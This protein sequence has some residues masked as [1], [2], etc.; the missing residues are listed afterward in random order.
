MRLQLSAIAGFDPLSG[1]LCRGFSVFD[2]IWLGGTWIVRSHL[3]FTAYHSSRLMRGGFN[4]MVTW[5]VKFFLLTFLLKAMLLSPHQPLIPN[6]I[7]YQIEGS[8]PVTLTQDLLL[9]ARPVRSVLG[10]E[11]FGIRKHL[12][13][14]LETVRKSRPPSYMPASLQ[15]MPVLPRPKDKPDLA[16]LWRELDRRREAQLNTAMFE[17]ASDTNRYQFIPTQ[18]KLAAPT[19]L[20]EDEIEQLDPLG[21]HQKEKILTDSLFSGD[22]FDEKIKRA[23]VLANNMLDELGI[24]G[25]HAHRAQ[26]YLVNDESDLPIV[27]DT[28]AS[29]S[30]T[31]FLSD[32]VG[33]LEE[34][35]VEEMKGLV[36]SVQV[37]GVGIVEWVIRDAN[38]KVG[39][40]RTKAYYIPKA[41]IRLFCPQEYFFEDNQ[42]RAL[43]DH[44][45]VVLR[46]KD[47][48]DLYF[49]WNNGNSLPVML[50]D[51]IKEHPEVDQGCVL[52]LLANVNEVNQLLLDTNMNLT[53]DQ[54]E[55]LLW[56][57]RLGHA[58]FMWTQSLMQTKNKVEVGEKADPPWLRV[59]FK[60]A[61][62]CPH[63]KCA[64][65][66]LGK[67]HRRTPGSVSTHAKP[68]REMAIRRGNLAPG[69]CVSIDQYVCKTPGRLATT[70]GKEKQDLRYTGGTIFVDHATSFV[71]IQ[72]QVSL[73][74]GET[75]HSKWK[76]ET[77]LDTLGYRVKEYRADNQ[78]FGAKEFMDDLELQGQQITFSGVGAHFQN[79]VAERALQ[80]IT[81]WARTMMM[82]QLVHWPDQFDPSLW[83][84]A[85]EHAAHLWN[86]MPKQGQSFSPLEILSRMKQPGVSP[87]QQARVW[88]CPA[89]VLDPQLHDSGKKLPKW[90]PRSHLGMYL[91]VS[92][93]HAPTVGRILNL[94][95]GAIT[96]QYHIM[97]DE[98]FTT[99]LGHGTDLLFN[100]DLWNGMLALDGLQN[101][102]DPTDTEDEN[103]PFQELYDDFVTD[104][105]LDEVPDLA[106]SDTES[107]D[108]DESVTTVK[109]EDDFAS[110]G[111]PAILDDDESSVG[112]LVP[113][114]EES[115]AND[116][117]PQT[118]ASTDTPEPNS[119]FPATKATVG[120]PP[121][122]EEPARLPPRARR[123][124]PRQ[125]R[126]PAG[127]RTRSGNRRTRTGRA[128]KP[129]PRFAGTYMGYEQRKS[130]A[131]PIP[132]NISQAQANLYQAGANPNRKVRSSALSSQYLAT[133]D[134]KPEMANAK[135]QQMKHILLQMLKSYDEDEGTLEEWHPLAFGAKSNDPD[136]MDWFEA[137]N[138]PNRDGFMEAA[139]K[140]I[141]TLEQMDVWEVVDRKDWMN[142]LPSTWAFRIKRYPNGE[143]RKLKARFCV[144]GDRQIAN[145]DYFETFA[146]VVNWNTVRLLL[147]LS[148]ELGLANTQ[149][150]FV[151]A[152]V[153]A[154]IDK[155]PDYDMMTPEEQSRT[156]VFVEM[157][158]GFGQ[159]GRVLKLKKSLYGLR[160]AP[161]NF[162]NH[163]KGILERIGFQQ[164]VDVDPC[165]FISDKVMILSYVDDCLFFA[166][167]Q[168]DVD[169][170]IAQLK[171][172]I[173]LEVEDDVAGFLGVHIDKDQENGKVTLTQKGL[174]QKII[175]ALDIAD[176]PAV[177][178]PATEVLGKDEDGDPADCTF[179]YAS[180]VGALWYLYGHSRPDL[181]F[182]VSQAARF[183]FAPKRSHELALIRIGQY[184][185]GTADKGMIMKPINTD[186]LQMDVYVDS[187]FMGL[188]GKEKRTDPT[189]AKSRSGH[190]ILLNSC[191]IIWSSK[192]QD[193]IA[194]STMMA[195]Y[196]A[197]SSSMREVLPL[198]SLVKVISKGCGI[199]RACE[200]SFRTT[201]WEDN[202][203][204]LTLANL[205]PGQQT[206]RSKH[207]DCRV[208]WF[209]S[210]L[211]SSGPDPIVVEKVE[212]A[213]QL[214]DLF[215]KPLP[216]ETF[217]KL[218]KLLMGW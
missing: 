29:L 102:L 120:T 22:Y 32:F 206:P 38:G 63:P 192:L 74:T 51:W 210:H 197:L 129:N 24:R 217:Q 16:R 65:C 46:T 163:L 216:R 44:K 171:K 194:L 89:Y 21:Y 26:A 208:H 6:D 94:R 190:V 207:Y 7:R 175:D 125:A 18:V 160:Q 167:D 191:P 130:K 66:Q 203:G 174:I 17:I 212:S 99:V 214:A 104:L 81:N 168:S 131:Q 76:M 112:T 146:P 196:Y 14:Q 13:Y 110:D 204:A 91:G 151:A 9:P 202:N 11:Q 1:A 83:P 117:A 82:H 123:R 144:R 73:R 90:K 150:D 186:R 181:G 41:T 71:Y 28:G 201:V 200:T 136:T 218:R 60:G 128:V 80:T 103:L 27:F 20:F 4:A 50:P 165:L 185:K 188:H 31:P 205:D 139:R 170:A 179:N 159:P 108:D 162:F 134:W 177:D 140:E 40:I 176:L 111:P 8:L 115:D 68:E 58:G 88:G 33:E 211:N 30:V 97:F 45:G 35:D 147:T 78:P 113:R 107:N 10:H 84:F 183:S 187:D 199:E 137:M 209:R 121:V 166:R 100:A 93:T 148:A 70:L 48:D 25:A 180:V 213:L 164:A 127:T 34:P 178:T 105:R 157:P 79:G 53:Q 114:G 158:R 143:I 126:I 198:R 59:K 106:P 43:L 23:H 152:F 49:P 172:H 42:T 118:I 124:Q 36:D 52:G 135:T 86:N 101:N 173:V 193:S 2:S 62:R 153:N 215:T 155:P 141:E 75:L 169:D 92:P 138:G 109:E 19:F 161:R 156:G 189:S 15:L 145:V 55:L 67:Q 3:M 77:F 184:L 182:A 154:D 116:L 5:L 64:A 69:D 39:I 72:N 142:V 56:H 61:T 119:P 87:L 132:R 95:T 149:V 122:K 57:Q 96:P 133:L 12:R 98:L 195:E 85:L 54:K 37:K 47:L